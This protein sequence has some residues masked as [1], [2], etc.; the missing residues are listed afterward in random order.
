MHHYFLYTYVDVRSKELFKDMSDAK[1]F[2]FSS[3][4]K[5]SQKGR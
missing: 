3:K 4:I 2:D 1:N 5:A